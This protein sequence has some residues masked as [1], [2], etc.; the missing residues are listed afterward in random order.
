MNSRVQRQIAI[1]GGLVLLVAALILG[2]VLYSHFAG[3]KATPPQLGTVEPASFPV[4][5]T[6]SGIVLNQNLINVSFSV[7]GTLAEVDVTPGAVVQ[8]GQQLGKLDD[9]TQL[10]EVAAAQAA[11]SAGDQA[12]SAANATGNSAA[13][14]S[15]QSQLASAQAELTRAQQDEARTILLAP[16]SGTVLEVNVQVGQSVSAG[17]TGINSVPGSS[18]SITDPNS[19]TN[20]G[21]N[22]AAFLIGDPTSFEV[23]APFSQSAATQL[24]AGQVGTVSFDALPG[25]TLTC[26]VAGVATAASLINGVPEYYAELIPDGTDPRLKTGQTSTVSVTVATATHVL[27]VPNQALFS[28]GN[29]QGVDVWQSGKAVATPVTTGLIGS[30][31]T[32]ITSGLNAG[33]QVLLTPTNTTLPT[34]S[35]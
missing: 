32:Q 24:K 2:P 26:K 31:L 1:A 30:T 19:I 33:E 12:V 29:G 25:L 11:V 16:Q 9:T 6:A 14:A 10:A 7:A 13:I 21:G 15:A 35:P 5:D 4:I 23:V 20:P 3:K 27:S 18:G 22:R 8:K 34:A 28:L 17:S